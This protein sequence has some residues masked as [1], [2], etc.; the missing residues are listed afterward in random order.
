MPLPRCFPP[1]GLAL[2]LTL[3]AT[4]ASA[5]VFEAVG[6]RALGM[7]G[8]FVAVADD[9]TAVYWNPAGMATGQLAGASVEMG[10]L[11]IDVD[12]RSVYPAQ[13]R[14]GGSFY[15]FN[16]PVIGLFYYGVDEAGVSTREL[17]DRLRTTDDPRIALYV[18][19]PI[20]RLHTT[21]LGV[22][23]AQTV[24]PG[25]HVA[26]AFKWV[27]GEAGSALPIGQDFV[28]EAEDLDGRTS[29]AFDV[30]LGVMVAL[31]RVRLGVV[32]RNLLEPEFETGGEVALSLERQVRAGASVAVTPLI[33]A[34]LDA[35]LT[36]TTVHTGRRR[37]VAGGLEAW[38]PGRRL[39]V[40]GGVRAQTEGDA[41]PAGTA[42]LSLG[43]TSSFWLEGYLVRGGD[44]ADKAW[45]IGLRGGW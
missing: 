31:G 15:G 17:R 9:A 38:L 7:G 30:D 27:R 6:V 35:D 25:V 45:G 1:I 37:A 39:G 41:R 14:V 16:V 32:G 19:P 18:P 3:T 23:L 8:A 26:G 13:R 21:H 36:T 44:V 2:L 12:E 5:Q 40:R 11:D 24:G 42:G 10:W 34:A 33:T 22:A 28:D 4:P 43:L 29:S 20:A